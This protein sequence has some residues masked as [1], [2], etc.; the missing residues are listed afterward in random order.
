MSELKKRKEKEK[1][2]TSAL[3]LMIGL[4]IIAVPVIVFGLMLIIPA[5]QTG[6]PRDGNRFANDLSNAIT[7]NDVN[8]INNDLKS[9]SNVDKVEVILSEG[10]LKIYIDAADSLG[11]DAVDSLLMDAYGRVT[12]KLPVAK[13]FTKGTEKMYDLNIGV[14]TT[15]EES[16]NR[17][18]KLLHKNAAEETYGIDDLAHAKDP[19]LVAEL[20]GETPVN[21]DPLPEPE[22]GTYEEQ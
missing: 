20:H 13:Y 19:N 1:I 18:F 3:V 15:V 14:Y 17:Q 9:L 22:E 8:T 21:T 6:T 11:S 4:M 12:A 10:Q 5:T 2:S 7:E 16:A